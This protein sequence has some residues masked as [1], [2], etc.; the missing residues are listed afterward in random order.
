MGLNHNLRFHKSISELHGDILDFQSTLL[1]V[2][3][4]ITNDFEML[5]DNTEEILPLLRNLRVRRVQMQRAWHDAELA[6]PQNKSLRQVKKV[7]N[8]KKVKPE[9]VY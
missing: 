7:Q 8:K 3:D 6:L 5:I 9:R 4:Q 1:E 2:L